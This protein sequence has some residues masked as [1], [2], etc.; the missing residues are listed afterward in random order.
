MCATAVTAAPT[1]PQAAPLAPP[2]GPLTG[3]PTPVA[4]VTGGA[5]SVDVNSTEIQSIASFAAKAISDSNNSGPLRLVRVVAAQTT[6]VA[7]IRYTLT[8]QLSGT[9]G[10]QTC[11]ATVLDQPWLATRTLISQSCSPVVTVTTPSPVPQKTTTKKAATT[12]KKAGTPTKTPVTQKT[13][14][15]ESERDQHAPKTSTTPATILSTTVATKTEKPNQ[16]VS[17]IKPSPRSLC[18]DNC[19]G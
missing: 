9:G 7:G 2:V 3:V 10:Q 11:N 12:T 8:L 18:F 6:V 4:P 13:K 15:P 17:T 16:V 14:L 1:L 5:T 19:S